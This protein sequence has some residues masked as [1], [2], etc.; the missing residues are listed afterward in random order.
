MKTHITLKRLDMD[1]TRHKIG[2]ENIKTQVGTETGCLGAET[3][4]RAP[5]K[6]FF[7]PKVGAGAP[8][9]A[10]RCRMN[11]NEIRFFVS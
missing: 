11:S 8:I 2:F 1:F 9:W 7:E 5:K 6:N 3:G 10:L 4:A